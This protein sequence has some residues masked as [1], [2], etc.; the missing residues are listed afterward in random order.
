VPLGM[1]LAGGVD[2]GDGGRRASSVRFAFTL[3]HTTEKTQADARSFFF[4][5]G[6]SPPMWAV[7]PP[8]SSVR[9]QGTRLLCHFG[10]GTGARC[11]RGR[12]RAEQQQIANQRLNMWCKDLALQPISR[13]GAVN[14]SPSECRRVQRP[15]QGRSGPNCSPVVSPR[16][17]PFLVVSCRVSGVPPWIRVD[18]RPFASLVVQRRPDP[19]RMA[20]ATGT[21]TRVRC[22]S[23]DSQMISNHDRTK[24]SVVGEPGHPPF[25]RFSDS[26]ILSQKYPCTGPQM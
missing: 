16:F 11:R 25:D 17:P 15:D 20:S 26:L 5:Y 10:G 23:F 13:C 22:T 7:L 2:G 6:R 8:I 1:A 4:L 18:Y 3:N 24:S 19:G 9:G 12:Q 14:R 21:A